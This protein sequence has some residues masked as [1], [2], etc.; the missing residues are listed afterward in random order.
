M[1]FKVDPQPG[2][3]IYLHRE[4]RGSHKHLF[5]IAISNQAIYLPEQKW[6]TLKKD[7]WHFRRYPLSEVKAVQLKKQRPI[8]LFLASI[9]MLLF[10]T[11]S[12]TV[13]MW[14]SL[15]W[16]PGEVTYVSGWPFAIAVGGLVLPFLARKRRTLLIFTT[17]KMYKWKPQLA[18]D[19]QTR[20]TS[21][22]LQD[23]VIRACSKAGILAQCEQ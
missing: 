7:T 17:S 16:Q 2:E 10:G 5:G 19:K 12:A 8:P 11:A 9:A 15:H 21:A 22:E 14:R 1:A 20:M 3:E 4:F 18:V 23:S 13:M 6:L